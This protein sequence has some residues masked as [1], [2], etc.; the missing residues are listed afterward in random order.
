VE[1]HYREWGKGT[2]LIFLHGGWGY[3]IYPIDKQLPVLSERFRIIVPDRSGYGGS[4]EINQ[5]PDRFHTAAATEML[6]FL[7]ALDIDRAILW[8]HSDGAVIGAIM[9]ILSP[10]R[11][12]GIIMEAFHFERNKIGSKEFFQTMVDAPDS[13]GERVC[14]LLAHEHGKDRWRRVL[15]FEGRAWLKIIKESGDAQKDFFNSRLPE[16]CAPA[17]FIHGALDPRTEPTELGALRSQLPDVPIK[18][19]EEGGHS[20]HSES[21]SA[22]ECNRIL[23]EFLDQIR[24]I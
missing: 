4:L 7:D 19:I 23:T 21:R 2:P 5:L 8:G 20:P 24:P 17:I 9:G 14:D 3:E 15:E 16:F 6:T 1:I 12:P 13:F 18:L 10:E 22:E 11:F